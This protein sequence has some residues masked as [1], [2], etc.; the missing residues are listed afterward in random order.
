MVADRYLKWSTLLFIKE[1][2]KI[3]TNYQKFQNMGNPNTREGWAQKG[4]FFLFFFFTICLSGKGYISKVL[5]VFVVFHS[6]I[7]S[8]EFQ[9]KK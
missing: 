2:V 8:L 5:N 9:S 4:S 6:V 7:L 1:Y 3:K